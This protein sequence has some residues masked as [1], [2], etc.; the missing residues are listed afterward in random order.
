MFS[1]SSALGFIAYPQ[2]C[3]L[4]YQ[5]RTYW[6]HQNQN[7]LPYQAQALALAPVLILVPSPLCNLPQRILPQPTSSSLMHVF[8]SSYHPSS[9]SFLCLS[10][11]IS[12]LS[13]TLLWSVYHPPLL[14]PSSSSSHHTSVSALLLWFFP[15]MVFMIW[16]E[17][18]SICYFTFSLS[19]SSNFSMAWQA[20]LPSVVWEHSWDQEHL[21][22]GRNH[23]Q[24]NSYHWSQDYSQ[25]HPQS[26]PSVHLDHN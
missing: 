17:L 4:A 22:L 16:Q 20:R 26:V 24:Y 18:S 13:H 1:A 3:H 8:I 7:L 23:I 11:S 5:A 25:L 10:A 21:S 9:S 6:Q 15:V 2:L 19:F 14:S 12:L